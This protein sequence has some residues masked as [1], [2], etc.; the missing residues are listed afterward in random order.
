MV[1]K[2]GA[3]IQIQVTLSLELALSLGTLQYLLCRWESAVGTR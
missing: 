2:G 1:K 3:Q